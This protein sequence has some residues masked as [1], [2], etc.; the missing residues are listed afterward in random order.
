M[1]S[2][3]GPRQGQRAARASFTCA[4]FTCADDMYA[5]KAPKRAQEPLCRSPKT[6]LQTNK[7]TDAERSE[8]LAAGR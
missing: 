3:K 4:S 7:H 2:G 1:T 5:N 6:L 8:G